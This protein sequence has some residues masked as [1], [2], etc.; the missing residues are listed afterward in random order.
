MKICLIAPVPPFRGGIAKYCY[1]LAQELGKRHE[2]LLLSYARLYP[3]VLFGG[4]TQTDPAIDRD[5]IQSEFD[6]LSYDIDSVNPLSWLRTADKI[7]SFDPDTV[8]FP[9]WVAYWTP[10]Y[11]CLIQSLR[12]KGIR[13]LFLCINVFEHEDNPVKK[14]MTRLVLRRVDAMIVHS[15]KEK[16]EILEFDPTARVR[17]HLLPLFTYQAVPETRDDGNLHLLFFGFVRPY[18]GLDILL[19]AIAIL[20]DR[21]VSLKIAGEFWNGKD[22]YLA[23]IEEYG[24]ADKVDIIDR[25]LSD[26][27]MSR[28]FAWADLVVL[29]Y[30]KSRTSGVIATAYGYGKPVLA[31]DVGGFHEV[32]NDGCTGKIVPPDNP[33]AFAEGIEWFLANREGDFAGNIAEFTAREMSWSSLVD[34][35]EDASRV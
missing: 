27:E 8:I 30:R 20:K 24:I 31:T 19:K 2:L 6:N 23:I 34:M 35:I 13:V 1:S 17:K 21:A 10:M 22:E 28:C 4:K 32:V 5:R 18:K 3:A 9:W 11:L 15:D 33:Q 29:P 12:K 16:G 26:H 14:F 25:Y 7:S